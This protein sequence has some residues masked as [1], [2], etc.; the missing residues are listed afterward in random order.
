MQHYQQP[1]GKKRPLVDVRDVQRIQQ[2]QDRY[3][4]A[5]VTTTGGITLSAAQLNLGTLFKS[6]AA[7]DS[8]WTMPNAN[9]IIPNILSQVGQMKT[10]L[11]HGTSN[12][13]LANSVDSPNTVQLVTASAAFVINKNAG[14]R[15]VTLL[16][17]SANSA[18]TGAVQV[19]L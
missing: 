11:I 16:C 15:L 5:N 13:T 17:N 18:A 2:A 3:G 12:V 7:D 19:L 14:G 6:T 8:T 10:I 9:I 1:I 4:Y